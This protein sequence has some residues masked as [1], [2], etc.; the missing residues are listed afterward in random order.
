M[1]P[2]ISLAFVMM[3]Q[4]L[5][6]AIPA[7][8]EFCEQLNMAINASS[9]NFSSI[10][11]AYDDSIDETNYFIT[12]VNL[13]PLWDCSVIE[14][15]GE[16][17]LRCSNGVGRKSVPASLEDIRSRIESCRMKTRGEPRVTQGSKITMIDYDMITE[18]RSLVNVKLSDLKLRNSTKVSVSV[19]K[20]R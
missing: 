18:R 5:F 16:W 13:D 2:I 10:K 8:A 9:D 3:L 1:K 6:Y 4:F 17:L 7:R 14:E 19:K 15:N 11:G 12:S 20:L